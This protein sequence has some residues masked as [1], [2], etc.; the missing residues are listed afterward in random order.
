[1]AI[2]VQAQRVQPKKK[3]K[4]GLW[5]TIGII[6]ALLVAAL[7][8][9]VIWKY[10]QPKKRSSKNTKNTDETTIETPVETTDDTEPDPIITESTTMATTASAIM[11][12]ET[13]ESYETIPPTPVKLSSDSFYVTAS[14]Y[15]IQD[16]GTSKEKHFYPDLAVDGKLKTAWNV[17][18]HDGD[19]TN[20][21]GEYIDFYFDRGTKLY[22]VKICPGWV[23]D[24][25]KY[26]RFERNYAPTNV[27]VSSGGISYDIDLTEYAYNYDLAYQGYTFV[28]PEWMVLEDGHLRITINSVRNIY[29]EKGKKDPWSDCCI[30]EISF[31]GALPG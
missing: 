28:F 29:K 3:S 14:S 31:M 13:T 1:V 15:Y 26:D 25:S 27:T 20:G 21:R 17:R 7:A 6:A 23:Y 18:G 10:A 2:P 22:S 16:K 8:A 30:S 5:I 19:T 12:T 9:L 11:T 4:K 24:D